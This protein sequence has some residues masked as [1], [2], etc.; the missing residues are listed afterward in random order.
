MT[1]HCP[2]RS[3]GLSGGSC[4]SSASSSR[5]AAP[6]SSTRV[7]VTGSGSPSAPSS[8]LNSSSVIPLLLEEKYSHFAEDQVQHKDQHH[9]DSDGNEDDGRVVDG[10]APG[11]PRH[12]P[13][14]H[15]D[16]VEEL[17]G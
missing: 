16:L 6:A 12:L 9:Q 13:H 2:G 3:Y 8:G 15:I 5:G 10:L 1:N 4:S 17:P 14:L 11:R 7:A